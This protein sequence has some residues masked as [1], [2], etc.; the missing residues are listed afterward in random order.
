MTKSQELLIRILSTVLFVPFLIF[1]LFYEKTY[2][3][4]VIVAL[5][6]FWGITE[7]YT[8]ARKTGFKPDYCIGFVLAFI[9]W[10]YTAFESTSGLLYA[11]PL[12]WMALL[13]GFFYQLIQRGVELPSAVANIG[14]TVL[15]ILYIAWSFSLLIDMQRM[16]NGGWY[17]MWL[18]FVTWFCDIGAY[19][20]GSRIGKHK[21]CPHISPGKTVEGLIGGLYSVS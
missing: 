9:V 8:L 3:F 2:S 7:F 19:L 17:L 18:I 5:G 12:L 10:Y 11:F 6:T 13:L 16:D 21:L 1:S 14:I 4:P 15:G 20:V